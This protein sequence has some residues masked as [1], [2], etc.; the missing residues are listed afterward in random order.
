[1]GGLGQA[2]RS[3]PGLPLPNSHQLASLK[4]GPDGR[5]R[6]SFWVGPACLP[7]ADHCLQKTPDFLHSIFHSLRNVFDLLRYIARAYVYRIS[8]RIICLLRLPFRNIVLLLALLRPGRVCLGPRPRQSL[9]AFNV[10]HK[11]SLHKA[12]A[13]ERRDRG[14]KERMREE[15]EGLRDQVAVLNR[16]ARGH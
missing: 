7:S 10:G 14:N 5:A 4:P 1:M 16:R 12:Q 6:A 3:G 8:N 2:F 9:R 13:R 15:D 11:K